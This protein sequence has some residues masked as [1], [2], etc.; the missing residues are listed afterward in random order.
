M[1]AEETL[2]QLAD[3]CGI[4]LDELLAELNALWPEPASSV[5]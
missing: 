5:E 4:E 1:A 2:E 3:S